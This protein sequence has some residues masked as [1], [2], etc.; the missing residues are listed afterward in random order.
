MFSNIRIT[1]THARNINFCKTIFKCTSDELSC[2]KNLAHISLRCFS[3]FLNPVPRLFS[4]GINYFNLWCVNVVNM[5]WCNVYVFTLLQLL[6][7]VKRF[8]HQLFLAMPK[9]IIKFLVYPKTQLQKKLKAP[10]TK[11]VLFLFSFTVLLLYI[12]ISGMIV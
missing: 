10:I 9:T 6:S 12:N 3:K 2:S 1:H 8:L 7:N 4:K 5:L 11:Y